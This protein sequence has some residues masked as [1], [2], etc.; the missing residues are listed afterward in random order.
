MVYKRAAQ[1]RVHEKQNRR[2]KKFF[3]K[4][5]AVLAFELKT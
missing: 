4:T 1:G 3:F 5:E 2:Y